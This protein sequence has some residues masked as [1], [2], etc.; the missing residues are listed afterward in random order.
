MSGVDHS[1]DELL[2]VLGF[3]TINPPDEVEME[4]ARIQMCKTL[5]VPATIPDEDLVAL[6]KR[7]NYSPS[8]G[9]GVSSSRSPSA[10]GGFQ[11]PQPTAPAVYQIPSAPLSADP[12]PAEPAAPAK[13]KQ[14][15]DPEQLANIPRRTQ[16]G[17]S[18][19]GAKSTHSNLPSQG[20]GPVG[21]S[22]APNN[23]RIT[24][25]AIN[26][27][28]SRSTSA[29]DPQSSQSRMQALR[30]SVSFE[31]PEAGRESQKRGFIAT[32][33][34]KIKRFLASI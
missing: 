20:G 29:G 28:L 12:Q 9:S 27:L 17:L 19:L 18:A 7:L 22:G 23:P 14:A 3:S 33:I 26:P 30:T 11:R 25:S 13:S 10:T 2:M 21:Q 24:Q 32:A 8:R 1:S 15:V 31:L 16:G 34:S 6:A 4:E 5:R